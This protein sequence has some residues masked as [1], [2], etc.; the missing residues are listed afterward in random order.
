MASWQALLLAHGGCYVI[1]LMVIDNI[2][3][4]CRQGLEVSENMSKLEALL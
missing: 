1:G 3:E 4:S 2:L